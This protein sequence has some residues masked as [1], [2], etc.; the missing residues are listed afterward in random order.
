MNYVP[1]FGIQGSTYFTMLNLTRLFTCISCSVDYVYTRYMYT[2]TLFFR[3]PCWPSSEPM[4][5]F[6]T[7]C[8]FWTASYL[9]QFVLLR[10]IPLNSWYLNKRWQNIFNQEPCIINVMNILQLKLTWTIF[11][12]ESVFILLHILTPSMQCSVPKRT[13]LITVW[14][15]SAKIPA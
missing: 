1:D 15:Y 5:P 14:L 2:H 10:F 7:T 3:L 4:S 13:I 12:S 9:V 8:V 6:D 11:M